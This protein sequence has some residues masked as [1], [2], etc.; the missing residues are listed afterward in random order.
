MELAL[1]PH[2]LRHRTG[3]RAVVDNT[4]DHSCLAQILGHENVNTIKRNMQRTRMQIAQATE[5]GTCW[6]RCKKETQLPK[7]VSFCGKSILPYLL[8]LSISVLLQLFSFVIGLLSRFF[9]LLIHSIVIGLIGH[10]EFLLIVCKGLDTGYSGA[11]DYSR[12]ETCRMIR[13]AEPPPAP[14]EFSN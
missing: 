8:P 12:R 10:R 6:P 9:L 4:N 1:D 11:F 5:P 14:P 3:H 2:F 13:L 7:Q